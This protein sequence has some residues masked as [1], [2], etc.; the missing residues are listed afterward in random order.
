[1]GRHHHRIA[2]ALILVVGH[3]AVARAQDAAS[4]GA[5]VAPDPTEV[6]QA[7]FD[8]GVAL[9]RDERFADAARA[10]RHSYRA[11]PRVEAM[12]NLALTYDRWGDHVDQA[13]GAYRTCARDDESGRYRGYA[14][15]RSAEIERELALSEAA[16]P[17]EE[18]A[19]E[20]EPVAGVPAPEPITPVE[21]D[22][23][24]LFGGVAV[25]AAGLVTLGVAIGFAVE[26]SGLVDEL[27]A[28][29]GAAP[30][31]VRG[32]P[33]HQQLEDARLYADLATGLYV[34]TAVLGAAAVTLF[35][36]DVVL[37]EGDGGERVSLA[38]TGS[39]LALRGG[40]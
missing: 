33:E 9:L 16:E 15:R 2:F 31:V 38:P 5:A 39:G 6:A 18:P 28:R 3:G 22:H 25:G 37:A 26:S 14:E 7:Q 10:F 29:L 12:C 40:F 32:S 4:S 36:L 21:P 1:M 19:P 27:V 17:V 11:S 24:L 30:T 23:G 35:V 20:D 8:Q 34:A 13:L